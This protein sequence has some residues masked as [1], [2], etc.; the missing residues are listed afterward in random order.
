MGTTFTSWEHV[1]D[2]EA[3]GSTHLQFRHLTSIPIF[4]CF[5]SPQNSTWLLGCRSSLPPSIR[6]CELTE[7][8]RHLSSSL[9]QTAGFRC[10]SPQMNARPLCNALPRSKQLSDSSRTSMDAWCPARSA[11]EFLSSSRSANYLPDLICKAHATFCRVT[12]D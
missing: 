10:P 1:L 11:R 5:G 6:Y 8:H 2:R 12:A 7:Q 9:L 3:F 4:T